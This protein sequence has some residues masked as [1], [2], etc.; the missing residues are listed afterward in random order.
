MS[1]SEDAEGNSRIPRASRRRSF[2]T[3]AVAL[4]AGPPCATDRVAVLTAELDYDLPDELIAREPPPERDGGRVLVIDADAHPPFAHRTVRDLASIVPERALLVV[5][6]T[7]VIP[8]RIHGAKASGGK[9]EI[10][11]LRTLDES[12]RRWKALGRASKT[13]RAG[14]DILLAD[15][16]SLRVD[17]RHDDGTL[18][19]SI[20]SDDPWRFIQR[21]GEIPLPPYLRRAPTDADRERYQTVF[22]ERPGAVAAPTAG[23]HLTRELLGALAARGVERVS[24]TLHVSAGTFAPIMVDDLDKHVMHHEWFDIPD[25]TASAVL[26]AKR[27]GRTVVSVGTTALRA[28]ESWGGTDD[29]PRR[30]DTGLLIQP[31]YTFRVVDH[32]LTNFHLPRS[33]LLALVMAFAGSDTIRAAYR[34]AI[35]ERYRFFSYGDACYLRRTNIRG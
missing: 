20:P 5:N 32:L 1:S 22:A 29:G 2:G 16:A 13:V 25:A 14:T 6:D 10:F 28:L 23:L 24:V 27:D 33:T 18:T 30:G 12:G 15:G 11:L 4:A 19:V 34:D 35:A 26:A 9:V 8:A 17:E 21:H 3:V 7:R 31:G